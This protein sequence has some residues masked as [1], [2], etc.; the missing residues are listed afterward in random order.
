MRY[1]LLI[2]LFIVLSF[3]GCKRLDYTP[4]TQLA[5]ESP[6]ILIQKVDIFNGRDQELIK[7][8]DVLIKEGRI[9][10]I[11][12]NL[13]VS[14]DAKVIDGSGKTLMP[15]LIDTHVHLSGSG[16][17]PWANF[18]ADKD[19]NL[20]AYLYSGI[21]TIYDLGGI[22]SQIE[23]LADKVEEGKLI[24]P[25][26]YHTH[27]PITVKNSHPIPL[28]KELMG[29]PLKAMVNSMV[30]TV[31]SPEKA[32]KLI[33]KY[34]RHEI[35]FVKAIVDEIP[36]G[37]PQMSKE[38]L[39]ALVEA[40][41]AKG[42]KV[43]VHIGSPQ[44]ALDAIASGADVLAHGVWRGELSPEQAQQIADSRIPIIYTISGF[45][46]VDVIYQGQFQ[47]SP[48]EEKLVSSEVIEPVT[49]KNGSENA[50]DE[51]ALHDFFEDVHHH[52]ETILPNLK[53]L[54]KAGANIIVGTDSNLPGTYAG[55][56]YLQEMNRLQSGGMSNF[57]I[58]TGA[59][60]KASRLFLE[61]PDFGLVTEG[62]KA[63]LLLLDGNPLQDL[64]YLE[65]PA[66]ILKEGREVKRLK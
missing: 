22:S 3:G 23:K 30:P 14:S 19:H 11:G 50:S 33:D 64:K 35:D 55:A 52:S 17:A 48:A 12:G 40:S 57:D 63:D 24:G 47:P 42:F 56:S 18:P 10:Q 13:P 60:F 53:L 49:G 38:E 28:T 66:L 51:E 32:G 21:T 37:S 46:N 45:T 27:I 4:V 58:L 16:A 36:P 20:Q 9:R 39:T 44:N 31:E 8:Q 34:T 43:F 59:T 25:T 62:N 26:I 2:A 1:T 29:F 6:S 7:G 41:H 54:V 15:G 65:V 61:A 5:P